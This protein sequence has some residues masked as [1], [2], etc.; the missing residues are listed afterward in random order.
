MSH[1]QHHRK[2]GIILHNHFLHKQYAKDITYLSYYKEPI[3]KSDLPKK[4]FA[5]NTSMSGYL[6][7]TYIDGN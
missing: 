5:N 7:M 6:Y 3:L 1:Y 2:D 4:E